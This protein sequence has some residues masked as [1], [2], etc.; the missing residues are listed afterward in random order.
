MSEF[1]DRQKLIEM[2]KRDEG[3]SSIPYDDATGN[4][5]LAP[6]GNVTIGIGRHIFANPLTEDEMLYLLKNDIRAARKICVETIGQTKFDTITSHRR[7]ALTCLAFNLGNRLKT[8]KK[9]IAAILADD[10][11]LAAKELRDSRWA[12][13]VDPK[14]RENEGRDDRLALM[15]EKDVYPY[16]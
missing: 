12:K 9:M 7:L 8:F 15:L 5:V 3:V 11:Q 1:E 2:L 6:T 14:L 16:V 4:P 13:Q 10:W